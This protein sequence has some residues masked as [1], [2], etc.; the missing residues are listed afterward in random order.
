MVASPLLLRHRGTEIE[1]EVGEE[2]TV[3]GAPEATLTV[4]HPGVSQRHAVV[5][6]AGG[7]LVEDAGSTNG[8]FHRGERVER[9]RVEGPITVL[10]GHPTEGE[11][12]DLFPAGGT[13][14]REAVDSVA[15]LVAASRR[16]VWATWVL[17]AV[18]VAAI[19][20]AVIVVLTN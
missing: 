16:L 13:E 7:W 5:R 9:V 6:Y 17:T 18:V 2:A 12:L 14:Q 3:G 8:I 4:S 19:V 1:L 11:P 15:E 10:L 20:V